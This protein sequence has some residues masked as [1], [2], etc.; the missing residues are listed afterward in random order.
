M[1]GLFRLISLIDTDILHPEPATD[2]MALDQCTQ[3]IPQI[4]RNELRAT[5]KCDIFELYSRA[6][7][8]VGQSVVMDIFVKVSILVFEN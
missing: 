2:I 7:R 6:L 3:S 5:L 4:A 1:P 8:H